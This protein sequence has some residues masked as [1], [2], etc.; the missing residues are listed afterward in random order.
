MWPAALRRPSSG[1]TWSTIRASPRSRRTAQALGRARRHPA[2]GLRQPRLR[3]L[4]QGDGGARHHLR[5]HQPAAGRARRRAGRGLRRRSSTPP[6]PRCRARSP[7]RFGW[8][9][10]S[11]RSPGRRRRSASTASRSWPR[12]AC[13]AARSHGCAQAAPFDERGGDRRGT[14][15][16]GLPLSGLIVL[17][18]SSFIAA[19]AAAVALADFGADVI[20][21]E[22]PGEGD[23]H[24]HNYRNASY[25]QSDKNFPWQL[26]GRLKRSIALDLKNE[27]ARAVLERLIERADVMIVNFPPPA[28]ERLK[29]RWEDIEPLNSAPG[30]LLAHRL[31]RD[32]ARTATGRASTSPPISAAPASSTRRATRAVRPACRCPPRATAP[33]P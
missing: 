18:I 27:S 15:L 20:K 29:L 8:A 13:R 14:T 10:P 23:P 30:L 17:D 31:R 24:R 1:P 25:P 16:A 9:S 4:A 3:A 26:D 19:P 2:R 12:P 7:I 5:R 22:P 28:R 11:S 6:S 21:I 33:R 32:R